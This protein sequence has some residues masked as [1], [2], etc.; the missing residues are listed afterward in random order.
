MN[1]SSY[2]FLSH[3]FKVFA[4]SGY[5]LEKFTSLVKLL[6]IFRNIPMIFK[7]AEKIFINL[8]LLQIKLIDT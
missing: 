7:S 3:S 5:V 8:I 2:E 1:I 6:K 4:L